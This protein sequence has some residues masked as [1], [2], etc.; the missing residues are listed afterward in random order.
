MLCP[1][2]SVLR[3]IATQ[4]EPLPSGETELSYEELAFDA[5]VLRT[6][7]IEPGVHVK[8]GAFDPSYPG[9]HHLYEQALPQMLFQLK[10]MDHLQNLMYAEKKH[11]LLIILQGM[12]AAGK[13]G[14][15]R[16]LTSGINPAGCRVVPFKQPTPAEHKHDFLW[17][18][19]Q[20]VPARGE[21]TIFNRSHYEDVLV[22][23]VHQL[24]PA[25][26]CLTRYDMINDL[27]RLLAVENQTTILKFLL[28]ISKDEQLARFKGRLDDP[29]RRW[30]IS[31]SDYQEREYWDDYIHAFEDM[32]SK[33]ST[34]YAPWFVI[35]SNHKWFRDFVVSRIITHT[36]EDLNMRVPDPAVDVGRIRQK[37]HAAKVDLVTLSTSCQKEEC[38]DF[39]RANRQVR[40]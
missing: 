8:L 27:E 25:H 17:R 5:S 10:K 13:D 40:Q 2:D 33:T 4:G 7:K 1:P 36:L 12:D 28:H 18:V 22:V 16:H 24:V 14:L 34:H 21:V 19:H 15:I 39:Q 38:L 30:K 31:E 29:T 6:F 3:H 11:S 26:V 35:P 23:R 37:Y 9:N 20:H 32:L